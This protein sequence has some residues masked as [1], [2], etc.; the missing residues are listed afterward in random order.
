MKQRRKRFTSGTVSLL[1]SLLILFPTCSAAF[2]DSAAAGPAAGACKVYY[3]APNGNDANPGSFT[4]PLATL[5]TAMNLMEAGDVLFVRGGTY[6]AAGTTGGI[7]NKNGTADK[8]FTVLAYPGETPVFDGDWGYG[9][10]K[11][12]GLWFIGCSYW[13][14]EGLRFCKYQETGA[15]LDGNTHHM[16]FINDAFGDI[17]DTTTP[18]TIYGRSGITS[19]GANDILVD[20]C[21]FYR[22]GLFRAPDDRMHDHGI[23]VSG[24]GQRWTVR[25]NYFHDIPGGGGI[26]IYGPSGGNCSNSTIE[27]NLFVR[28]RMGVILG[29][30]SNTANEVHHNTFYQGTKCDVFITEAAHGNSIHHNLFG[31]MIPDDAEI[32]GYHINFPQLNSLYNTIDYNFYDDT[33]DSN[34]VYPVKV[35]NWVNGNNFNQKVVWSEWTGAKEDVVYEDVYAG[36]SSRIPGFG[37]EAHGQTGAMRYADAENGDFSLAADTECS[38]SGAGM[39]YA[40]WSPVPSPQE[41][42]VYVIPNSGFEDGLTGWAVNQWG[43]G[44]TAAVT[45]EYAAAGSRSLKATQNDAQNNGMIELA[46]YNFAPVAPGHEYLFSFQSINQLQNGCIGVYV[47]ECGAD[48]NEIKDAGILLSDAETGTDWKTHAVS[49]TVTNPNAQYLRI[50][51]LIRGVGVCYLDE[52]NLSDKANIPAKQ[53][54]TFEDTLAANAGFEEALTGNWDQVIQT[55][56]E[57]GGMTLERTTAERASGSYSLHLANTKAG[58]INGVGSNWRTQVQGG[59]KYLLTAKVKTSAST[60]AD[61]KLYFYVDECRD[62][63]THTKSYY[64]VGEVLNGPQTEWTTLTGEFTTDLETQRLSI[65]LFTSGIGDF[66]FDEITLVPYL[67]S[68]P[69][70][71]VGYDSLA[72][73]GSFEEV[74]AAGA[75]T[76]WVFDTGGFR[77]DKTAP[78]SDIRVDPSAASHAGKSV[79]IVNGGIGS[80]GNVNNGSQ[81]IDVGQNAVYSVSVNVKAEQLG[82]FRATASSQMGPAYARIVLFPCDENG[83]DLGQYVFSE[84]TITADTAGKWQKI[85]TGIGVSN[86]EFK[87]LRVFLLLY[88]EG[89]VWFDEVKVEQIGTVPDS[90]LPN[91]SFESGLNGWSWRGNWGDTAQGAAIAAGSDAYTGFQSLHIVNQNAENKTGVGTDHVI[92]VEG[93]KTYLIRARVKTSPDTASDASAFFYFHEADGATDVGDYYTAGSTLTGANDEWTVIT[94]LLTMQQRTNRLN[95]CLFLEGKGEAWFDDVEMIEYAPAASL[96]QNCSFESGDQGWTFRTGAGSVSVDDRTAFAGLN[97]MKI[98]NTQASMKTGF[99][100]YGAA[101]SLIDGVPG[102]TYHVTI[103]AK[104]SPSTAP[105]ATIRIGYRQTDASGQTVLSSGEAVQTLTGVQERWTTLS[106]YLTLSGQAEAFGLCIYLEGKG[107]AWIDEI[108]IGR[109]DENL[110]A[111]QAQLVNDLHAAAASSDFYEEQQLLVADILYGGREKILNASDRTAMN[112]ALSAALSELDGVPTKTEIDAEKEAARQALLASIR[113]A[114]AKVDRIADSTGYRPPVSVEIDKINRGAKFLLDQADSQARIDEI[115]RR[116]E[117]LM[118]AL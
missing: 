105:D 55:W 20:G 80:V 70:E 81:L 51:I 41:A 59:K 28:T 97:S 113:T 7:R 89:M 107:T 69:G 54:Y 110:N 112:A 45:T 114:K 50:W 19:E 79:R 98:T 18:E 49:Y 99:G 26:Q 22:I 72:Y 11:G 78:L 75:A 109:T 92:P 91:P 56:G 25:N 68:S 96:A 12:F 32:V 90:L 108:V 21:E 34:S 115:I 116:V 1:L 103:K 66:Y 88:G 29:G 73:N 3:I 14:I 48:K 5:D 2:A 82:R 62:N 17:Y 65:C 16:N 76:G 106:T 39:S 24:S 64:P 57:L 37:Q 44:L 30:V 63:N 100:N 58:N 6:L 33:D 9:G 118:G 35:E 71:P 40:E 93:G 61:A 53:Q 46:D 15:F 8:P 47:Q 94:A 86:A 31:P 4:E 111:L 10:G 104:T 74:S 67:D 77:D 85:S 13:H 42:P 43:T 38:I 60:A 83:N 23:Y 36:T 117:T 102:S 27:N 84:E 87:K 52:M 101:G 95:A